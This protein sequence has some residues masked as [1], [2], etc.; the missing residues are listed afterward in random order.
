MRTRTTII[1]AAA[2]AAA[3]AVSTADTATAAP[4]A[5]HPGPASAAQ[6]AQP[7]SSVDRN[8]RRTPAVLPASLQLSPG[9]FGTTLPIDCTI[10][11][12]VVTE[13]QHTYDFSFLPGDHVQITAGGCVQVGGH[14][15]SWKRYVD[16]AA[17]ND[18][19]HGLITIPGG[20]GPL[21]RLVNVVR[22]S[23]TVGGRGGSLVLGYEDEAGAYGDNGYYAHDN[24]TANQCLNVG[25]AFV[26][27]T[28]T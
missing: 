26:H 12:P 9:C 4:V 18:L 13:P 27:F 25:P 10:D 21:E 7:G 1:A 14:G 28:I 24:G 23:I 8:V 6:A 19:Y 22:R 15:L 20:T 3:A 11:Q 17:D 2:L 16:P 5:H